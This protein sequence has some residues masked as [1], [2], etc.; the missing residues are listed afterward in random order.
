MSRFLDYSYQK[1]Q[2]ITFDTVV[3]KKQNTSFQLTQSQYLKIN[4]LPNK[5]VVRAVKTGFRCL[6]STDCMVLLKNYRLSH[7]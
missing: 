3:S 7:H 2:K 1:R 5:L 6:L 4:E